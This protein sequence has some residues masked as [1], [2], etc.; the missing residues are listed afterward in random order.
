MAL[1]GA[2]AGVAT[3]V[4]P[5]LGGVLVDTA[6]L[7]VDLLRQRAGRRH[8]V[9][10]GLAARA[11]RSRP[12]GTAS[13]GSASR[14]AA[15]AC[16][17][18]SSASRRAS[19]TTGRPSPVRSP[20]GGSSWAASWSSPPSCG[21][22][23]ATAA[24]RCAAQPLRRP[25][26]LGVQPRHHHRLLRLHRDGLPADAVGAAGPRLLPDPG[27]PRCWRR[28]RSSR[29]SPRRWPAGSPTGSTRGCSRSVASSRSASRCW[30]SASS[31]RPTPRCGSS[32]WCSRLMGLGSSF[33]WAP[34]ATTAN[35]NLA[36]HQRG[37]RV[38]GLQRNRQVGAVLGSAAIAV[39]IDARLAANGLDLR[40]GRG[41]GGRRRRAAR[42][43]RPRP[44]PTRWRSRCSCCRPC[45]SSASSRCCSS[46][47]RATSPPARTC[48][49][50]HRPPRPGPSPERV[51][52]RLAGAVARRGHA[53]SGA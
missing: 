33:L 40:A 7:G 51:V 10:P 5:I 12:A 18:S 52:V 24:S 14:S 37:R 30:C 1:W 4:G 43:G 36:P 22:S 27:R 21:G 47:G 23:P 15:S 49:R 25:Q 2:A 17:C 45:C 13:T 26:L 46:S 50:R 19:S 39:L 3:L 31:W 29:S 32:C 6:R 11:A 16:S 9:R 53:T 44:S 48:A 34:L 38:R 42:P 8:R 28:W 41:I 35:R 20:C